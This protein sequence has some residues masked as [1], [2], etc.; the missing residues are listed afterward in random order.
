M[1]WNG[2]DWYY[3]PEEFGLTPVGEVDLYEPYYSFDIA[4]VW[5][6]EELK[7]YV[8]ATDSG[9]SCPSPFE[10]YTKPVTADDVYTLSSVIYNIE[11]LSEGISGAKR[12]LIYQ[13]K[14]FDMGVNR[15]A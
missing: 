2:N 13:V 4:K 11:Q 5:Y 15:K 9:D 3:N 12:D 6:H 14:S 7:G 10:D 1:G 8:F